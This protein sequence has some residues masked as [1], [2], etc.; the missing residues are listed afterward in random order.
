MNHNWTSPFSLTFRRPQT[1]SFE[2]AIHSIFLF[3]FSVSLPL[4]NTSISPA[5]S[6]YP[7]CPHVQSTSF[8]PFLPHF[9]FIHFRSPFPPTPF[10][11][12]PFLQLP[13]SSPFYSVSRLSHPLFPF[14]FVLRFL[15][16]RPIFVFLACHFSSSSSFSFSPS[17]VLPSCSSSPH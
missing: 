10:F 16:S 14:I 12:L 5:I 9:L 7:F 13:S 1:P 3:L 15:Q 17:F 2:T 4:L 8:S 6:T 11:V